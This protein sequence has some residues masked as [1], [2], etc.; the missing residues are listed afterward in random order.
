MTVK[1][2]I[3]ELE[4]ILT[5]HGDLEIEKYAR[6]TGGRVKF[7]QPY[8]TFRKILKGREWRQDFWFSY[9]DDESSKGEKV[10]EV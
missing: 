7:R 3:N 10:V 6:P 4:K 8:V 1:E 2:L 9:R 5:E